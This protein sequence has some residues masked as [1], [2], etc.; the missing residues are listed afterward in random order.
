MEKRHRLQNII[1]NYATDYFEGMYSENMTDSN[2]QDWFLSFID[3]TIT[4]TDNEVLIREITDEEIFNIITK[5]SK[6][7]SPGIDGLPIEFYLK[8]FH[9]IREEFCQMIR[10][11]LSGQGLTETQRKAIIILIFKG[12]D[13][14]LISS[15][16]PISLICVDARKI[17]KLLAARI[18]PFLNKCVSREQ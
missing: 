18:K 1:Y 10:N 17:S 14:E 16:R 4:I 9:I 5:F 15:W 11:S 6:N 13:C 12:G 2:R 8:F 7:K 3:K